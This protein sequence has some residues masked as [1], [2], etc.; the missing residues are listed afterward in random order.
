[1]NESVLATKEA[2]NGQPYRISGALLR[3][4]DERSSDQCRYDGFAGNR[5]DNAVSTS[6]SPIADVVALAAKFADDHI[7]AECHWDDAVERSVSDVYAGFARA[8]DR[9][10]SSA[11]ERDHRPKEIAIRQPE[12]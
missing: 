12:P 5:G 7:A 11:R 3:K 2:R 10:C 9:K 1:M 8:L 4:A 6:K